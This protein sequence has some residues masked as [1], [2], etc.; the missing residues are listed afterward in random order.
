MKKYYMTIL[1]GYNHFKYECGYISLTGQLFLSRM[2][3]YVHH[4]ILI[5]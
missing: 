3:P 2:I 1:I 5:L 4:T